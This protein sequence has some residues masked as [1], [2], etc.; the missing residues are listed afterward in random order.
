MTVAPFPVWLK[1]MVTVAGI[2]VRND[3]VEDVAKA[4]DALPPHT[5]ASMLVD[6]EAGRRL[7]LPWLSGAV[8]RIGREVRVATPI[9]GF[10]AAVLRPFVNGA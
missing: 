6:L 8:V 3:M 7:E 1:G 10:I 5:R 4:Y 9:H 2:P